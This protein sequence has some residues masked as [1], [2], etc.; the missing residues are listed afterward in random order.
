MFKVSKKMFSTLPKELAAVVERHLNRDGKGGYFVQDK[1]VLLAFHRLEQRDY[2]HHSI[3]LSDAEVNMFPP[4]R[5]E[6]IKRIFHKT[7]E[8]YYI[9][10][11]E[12]LATIIITQKQSAEVFAKVAE[13]SAIKSMAFNDL[14]DMV[15]RIYVKQAKQLAV[16]EIED[17]KKGQL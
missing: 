15:N 5:R 6:L 1:N 9:G 3:K 17:F 8:G 4:D 2:Y 7:E 11:S 14:S 16:K 10:L 12:L 13:E